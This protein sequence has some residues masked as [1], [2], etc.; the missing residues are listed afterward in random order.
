MKHTLA[1]LVDNSPGVLTRVTSL[2]SRRGYNI[3]SLAVGETQDTAVSRITIR[4][5]CDDRMLDQI[6][7][8]LGKLYPVRH[9]ALLPAENSFSRELVL[10]KVRVDAG[11]RGEIMQVANVFRARV[12]DL[13][14]GA[15]TLELTGENDKTA[16]FITLM[17]EYGILEIVRTGVVSLLRGE[18][19]L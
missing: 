6:I 4:V 2:F 8:Q 9:V 7:K 16:A 19:T 17:E 12:I 18:A 1:A 15:I 5:D 3:E 11:N 14:R 13:S 10:C